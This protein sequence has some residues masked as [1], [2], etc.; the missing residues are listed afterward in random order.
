MEFIDG[1][2]ESRELLA[3]CVGTVDLSRRCTVSFDLGHWAYEW[4]SGACRTGLLAR[5]VGLFG[6]SV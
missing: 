2:L 4:A 3:L 6:Y 1:E 5:K